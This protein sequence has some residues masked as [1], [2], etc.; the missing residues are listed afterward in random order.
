MERILHLNTP[1]FKETC[2]AYSSPR[3]EPPWKEV[4]LKDL[5]PPRLSS[6]HLFTEACV[7]TFRARPALLLV[8]RI[9]LCSLPR[10]TSPAEETRFFPAAASPTRIF[11]ES[12]GALVSCPESQEQALGGDRRAGIWGRGVQRLFNELVGGE[13]KWRATSEE[14]G[15]L[16]RESRCGKRY[17]FMFPVH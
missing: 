17:P 7:F 1:S 11:S 6:R 2:L 9:S 15:E 10:G 8:A 12:C 14:T 16:G 3:T 5:P 4:C 13:M